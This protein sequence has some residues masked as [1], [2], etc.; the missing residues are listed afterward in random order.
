VTRLL[1]LVATVLLLAPLTA[2]AAPRAARA[3]GS[4]PLRVA[5]LIPFVA[6]ALA[7]AGAAVELVAGV[8]RSLAEPLAGDLID[9]GNPHSPSLER[10]AEAR[11]DVVIGDRALHALL[12]EGL[13]LGGRARLVLIEADGVDATLAALRRVGAEVGA[14]AAIEPRVAAVEQSLAA[15]RVAGGPSA[16]I[17][18]GTPGGFY[19]ATERH[20][21]GD[22]AARIGYRNA[23]A[24]LAAS[25]R[26]PGL[27]AL[28][29]EV[30]AGL[31][32]ERV[33]LVSHGDPARIRASLEER[34][35]AGGVWGALGASAAR[36]VHVLDPRLFSSNPG[37]G[38]VEAARALASLGAKSATPASSATSTAEP[39][40]R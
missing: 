14:A 1:R 28:N 20:W 35:G 9:L 40:A 29:D 30:V 36:G 25:D 3:A 38:L 22:L 2:A 7:D 4:A 39:R 10:L 13:A 11:P 17:L 15:L 34:I 37:L 8:R 16:L 24:G 27:V 12:A 31:R 21:L 23:A 33:L 18:F 6:D 32:P 5:V 26:F 19:A